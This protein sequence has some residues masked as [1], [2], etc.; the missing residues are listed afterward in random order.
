[1]LVLTRQTTDQDIKD[2]AKLVHKLML[3][4]LQSEIDSSKKLY[5]P[6]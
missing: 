6:S 5:L 1:M 2:Y 3:E 4:W